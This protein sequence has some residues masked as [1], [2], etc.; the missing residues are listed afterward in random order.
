MRGLNWLHFRASQSSTM[1]CSHAVLSTWNT[2]TH[3]HWGS[4]IHFSNLHLIV[5]ALLNPLK[6]H[7]NTNH[8][9][10]NYWRHFCWKFYKNFIK[11]VDQFRDYWY[12]VNIKSLN[13]WSW[14]TLPFIGISLIAFKSAFL[15]F[16]IQFLHFFCLI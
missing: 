16:S 4:P 3:L 8:L 6:F 12:F 11:S 7:M 2:F 5:L 14:D 10:V 15:V 13:P 9:I 1:G